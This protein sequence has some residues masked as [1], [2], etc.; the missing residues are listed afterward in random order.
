M[1][2]FL[3]AFLLCACSSDEDVDASVYAVDT[4]GDGAVD[5]EDQTHVEACLELHDPATCE[6]A[7]V[8]H[9]GHVDQE[10]A[11]D[12]HDGL[13]ATGHECADPA[14]HEDPASH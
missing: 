11:A 9:D 13:T 5:C 8:N 1:R 12:I 14:H 10:D 7:D 2:L 4:D 3:C 6:A